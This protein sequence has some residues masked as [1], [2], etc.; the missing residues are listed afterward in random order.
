MVAQHAWDGKICA[1]YFLYPV[2]AH[3]A[4]LGTAFALPCK[5]RTQNILKL[6]ILDSCQCFN[7]GHLWVVDKYNDITRYFQTAFLGMNIGKVI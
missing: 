1:A 5:T 7:Y 3:A 4:F 6:Q 2:V